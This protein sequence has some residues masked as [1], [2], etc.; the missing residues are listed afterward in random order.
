[1][2]NRDFYLSIT[3]LCKE[4]AKNRR[5]LEP[6]LATLLALV[7]Q[8][9]DR[10]ALTAQEVLGMLAA[11]FEAEPERFQEEWRGK[12]EPDRE[13]FEAVEGTLIRQIVDLHEMFD[14]GDLQN[15]YRYLGCKAPSGNSWY[16]LDPLTFLECGAEGAFGGWVDGDDSGREWVSESAADGSSREVADIS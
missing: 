7:R 15:P 1:M 16:N 8:V 13:G 9:R 12:H 5:E 4:K 11:A 10:Q 14:R 2:T 3:Q 6:Y